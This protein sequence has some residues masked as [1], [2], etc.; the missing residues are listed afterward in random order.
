M[1]CLFLHWVK[2]NAAMYNIIFELHQARRGHLSLAVAIDP[3]FLAKPDLNERLLPRSSTN[4]LI[5]TDRSS[6]ESS[7]FVR[8][9]AISR[10]KN[11]L[12]SGMH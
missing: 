8:A 10:G 2:I 12:N 1:Y 11:W 3:L 4:P 5:S 7:T 6:V 9:V